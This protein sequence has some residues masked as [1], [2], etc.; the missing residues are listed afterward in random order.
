M[1]WKLFAQLLV[2]VLV[3]LCGGWLGHHLSSQRDLL[4]ERRKLRVSYLLEA[5]RRLESGSN[6]RDDPSE[7]WEQIESAIADIQLLGSPEQVKFARQ[8]AQGIS[9]TN[10]ASA[11]NLLYDL[12]RSLRRELH[13]PVADGSITFLRFRKS[14]ALRFESTLVETGR[15][16]ANAKLEAAAIA[17]PQEV[18]ISNTDNNYQNS[19]IDIEN[20]WREIEGLVRERAEAT[21]LDVSKLGSEALLR[22]A[23]QSGVI[24]DFQYRSL[25]GLYVMRKLAADSHQADID[26]KKV[27]EFRNLIDAMKMVLEISGIDGR[28]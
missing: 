14:G 18:K 7:A 9:D 10:T 11:D 13:L 25:R 23:H 19:A 2:T 12:R 17:S 20:A 3:A 21:S 24:T 27:Q 4:N 28:K 15:S 22:T 26:D 8:F 6:R 1:D 16:V 5:Y